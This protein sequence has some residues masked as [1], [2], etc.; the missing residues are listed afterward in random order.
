MSGLRSTFLG[1]LSDADHVHFDRP[2]DRDGEVGGVYARD[3]H[4]AYLEVMRPH[5]L[6][7][8]DKRRAADEQ[9]PRSRFL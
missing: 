2:E 5:W 7:E 6:C 4:E 8:A 3:A 1:S 9:R